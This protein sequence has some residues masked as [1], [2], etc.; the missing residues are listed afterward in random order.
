MPG[1]IGLENLGTA[2][3]TRHRPHARRSSTCRRPTTPGTRCRATSR[4]PSGPNA[5]PGVTYP[6]GSEP[7]DGTTIPAGALASWGYAA[8]V[9]P[10][11]AQVGAPARPGPG[12]RDPRPSRRS[13]RTRPTCR[14]AACSGS[15]TTSPASSGRSAATRRTS[16]HDRPAGRRRHDGLQRATTPGARARSTPGESVAVARTSTVPA[17]A[18]RGAD[19]IR[20]RVPRPPRRV[21]RHTARR[22]GVRPRHGRNRAG[23]RAGRLC[24]DDPAPAGRRARQDRPGR[25]RGRLD[26][27]T[28]PSPSERRVRRGARDRR[29]R[30]L[31]GVGARPVSGAPGDAR[32]RRRPRRATRLTRSR[33]TR[34]PPRQHRHRPLVGRRRQRLRAGQRR[35]DH[36]GHRRP[37]ALGRQDRRH[38]RRPMAASSTISYEIAVTNLGDQPVSGVDLSRHTSTR[39]RRSSPA[40]SDEPGGTVTTGNPT[41]RHDVAVGHR[42]ARRPVRPR[43]S[44]SG[45]PSGFVPRGRRA[46]LA[47]RRRSPATELPAIL[48]DDPGA[49]RRHRSDDHPRRP[50]RGRRWWRRRRWWRARPPSIGATTPADGTVVT[51]P[52]T[53]SAQITPPEG[54]RSPRGRSRPA[55]PARRPRRSSRP[56]AAP[57]S[58]SRSPRPHRSTRRSCPTAPT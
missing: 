46:D 3:A 44:R 17:P 2:P 35:A 31:T 28:T 32:R 19:G 38:D 34:T 13:R 9:Q 8:V 43:S 39:S 37:Q 15:A 33:P 41:R 4:S 51:A 26:G 12:Q 52:T 27:R 57:A 42:D 25:D 7:I 30:R 23:P 36:H 50:D 45:R 48:S 6:G 24:D 55:R 56:A 18:A 47:T 5:F 49:A 1:V 53:I 14:F 21:R 29:H 22:D 54:Q 16:G 20:R 58:T 10:D 11:A 40:R